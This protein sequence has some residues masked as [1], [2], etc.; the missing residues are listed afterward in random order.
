[1]S[2]PVS[3]Y[4]FVLAPAIILASVVTA[5]LGRV[6]DKKGFA[7]SSWIS[8]L[9]LMAGY[10]LLIFFKGTA[11]VFIGSLLMM[12]GYLA[13]MAVFGARIRAL[14]PEGKSGM[15]QG[16]RIFAQVLLPGVIGP[17]IGKTVLKNAKTVINNDGTRSFVP[18]EGIFIAA[19]VAAAVLAL[20]LLLITVK[21]K[22]KKDA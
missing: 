13:G 22:E 1:M 16:V 14:T 20:F 4:V 21:R 8:L 18:N 11:L 17:F 3:A 6:Y 9:W 5:L 7:F 2:P 19:L 12:C 10:V 15:L